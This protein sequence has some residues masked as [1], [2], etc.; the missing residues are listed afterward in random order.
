METS[1]FL[2][3]TLVHV[4]HWLPCMAVAVELGP[5]VASSSGTAPIIVW[6][7][8]LLQPN[9][10]EMKPGWSA[11]GVGAHDYHFRVF[12]SA[13]QFVTGLYAIRHYIHSTNISRPTTTILWLLCNY[14]LFF[15]YHYNRTFS[16]YTEYQVRVI[17]ITAIPHWLAKGSCCTMHIVNIWCHP[18]EFNDLPNKIPLPPQTVSVAPLIWEIT[19]DLFWW[20]L[21][22]DLQGQ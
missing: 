22:H 11:V 16:V 8:F 18:T 10:A 21:R 3:P 2:A 17:R 1:L 19:W 6:I 12:F 4:Q 14:L 13:K 7:W 20:V 5:A 9:A 15:Y